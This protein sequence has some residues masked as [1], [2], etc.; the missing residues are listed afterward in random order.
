MLYL[1]REQHLHLLGL[2]VAVVRVRA[3]TVRKLG[4]GLG[5]LAGYPGSEVVGVMESLPDLGLLLE[6]SVL[7]P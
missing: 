6:L 2:V 5:A 4:G 7:L 1:L 3:Y